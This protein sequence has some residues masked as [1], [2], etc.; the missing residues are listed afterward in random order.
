VVLP[1]LNQRTPGGMP[2]SAGTSPG[3]AAG[4]PKMGPGPGPTAQG[5]PNPDKLVELFTSY[6][7]GQM[8]RNALIME[9]A[10]LSQGEGGILEMLETL[11]QTPDSQGAPGVPDQAGMQ[12]TMPGGDMPAGAP[13]PL[14]PIPQ[15]TEPLD[16]RHQRISMLLQE[17]GLS[18]EDADQMSTE[19]NQNPLDIKDLPGYRGHHT[20]Y[21]I[22]PLSYPGSTDPNQLDDPFITARGQIRERIPTES[23]NRAGQ[24]INL[25]IGDKTV[26]TQAATWDEA[27]KM[28]ESQGFNPADIQQALENQAQANAR[29]FGSSDRD[30]EP[31]W[32]EEPTSTLPTLEGVPLHTY[33]AAG[34]RITNPQITALVKEAASWGYTADDPKYMGNLNNAV[35]D[36]IASGRKPHESYKEPDQT[37]PTTK[38]YADSIPVSKSVGSSA[39]TNVPIPESTN[40]AYTADTIP[41]TS[42]QVVSTRGGTELP[43]DTKSPQAQLQDQWRA[44]QYETETVSGADIGDTPLGPQSIVSNFF[45]NASYVRQGADQGL[46]VYMSRNNSPDAW[47]TAVRSSDGKYLFATQKMASE[48]DKYIDAG[49][50]TRSSGRQSSSTVGSDPTSALSFF[51]TQQAEYGRF[52]DPQYL[53]EEGAGGKQ[54]Y[55]EEYVRWAAQDWNKEN[56]NG[57]SFEVGGKIFNNVKFK[58]KDGVVDIFDAS[59]GISPLQAYFDN[60]KDS[61]ADQ[62]ATWQAAQDKG[63]TGLGGMPTDTAL[64]DPDAGVGDAGP[65]FA[66]WSEHPLL[67]DLLKGL[68]TAAMSS[69]V[70]ASTVVQAI[71]DMEKL[72]TQAEIAQAQSDTAELI[73]QLREDGEAARAEINEKI[74]IGT[75]LGVIDEDITL[76]AQKEAA[77]NALSLYQLS[78]EMPGINADGTF[79][80]DKEGNILTALEGQKLGISLPAQ[81]IDISREELAQDRELK[82]TELFGRTLQREQVPG[83]DAGVTRVKAGQETLEAQKWGYT[84][85]LQSSE[86]AGMMVD[87]E[88]NPITIRG[89]NPETGLMDDLP[90]NTFE[91]RRWAWEK[92]HMSRMADLE[93]SRV[94]IE[95]QVANL[96]AELAASEQNLAASIEAGKLSEAVASRRQKMLLEQETELRARDQMRVNTL[97]SLS[98][99]AIMIFAKRFGLIEGFEQALGLSFGDDIID[100]PSMLPPNTMPNAQLLSNS[101]PTDR[102]IMLAEWASTQDISIDAALAKIQEHT[103]GGGRIS[104]PSV[105]GAAR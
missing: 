28:A 40:L 75:A 58:E 29:V 94:E 70:L 30:W 50:G 23:K 7:S 100:P 93:Q 9:L 87:S 33:N 92:D 88:G 96:N 74:A 61:Y 26:G 82:M 49:G 22:D 42:Y 15:L 1:G 39:V 13:K 103:P 99:P 17:Y 104:R 85:S 5:V 81:Q 101:T 67:G 43:D 66:D 76:A 20:P 19:L 79:V 77:A 35:R 71:T 24:F 14:E 57:G 72:N 6:T 25:T 68:T 32:E 59:Q 8:D 46:D 4:M 55:V 83:A 78:G 18:P 12:P 60:A 56:P 48:Y 34:Q 53:G 37:L 41:S 97:I 65:L 11:D 38:I 16:A 47:K 36:Y 27:A 54:S 69:E 89:R 84:K 95:L 2:D 3:P 80:T 31:D 105:L 91:A 51:K 73:A 102:R 90:I 62:L 10:A 63:K 45:G 44:G 86:L 21:T 64:L 98:D 52:F